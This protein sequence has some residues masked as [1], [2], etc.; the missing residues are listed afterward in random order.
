MASILGFEAKEE[1]K[2]YGVGKLPF[3]LMI[4]ETNK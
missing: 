4:K 1:I 3:L 2:Q